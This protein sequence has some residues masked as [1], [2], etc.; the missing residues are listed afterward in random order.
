MPE[1]LYDIADTSLSA[2]VIADIELQELLEH[3]LTPEQAEEES[4]KEALVYLVAQVGDEDLDESTAIPAESTSEST[5]TST[6]ST[7]EVIADST[8][9][10]SQWTGLYVGSSRNPVFGC[11][12]HRRHTRNV[13]FRPA[14]PRAQRC[15]T[16]TSVALRYLI[17]VT[18][19]KQS[20][21]SAL[22]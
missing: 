1:Y 15:E 8:A 9:P 13:S 3:S 17:V 12:S 19:Q 11:S 10:T 22:P 4:K 2:E 5:A 18:F 7:S 6:A 21:S 14:E 16:R 20:A